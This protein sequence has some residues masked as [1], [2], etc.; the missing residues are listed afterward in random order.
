[1]ISYENAIKFLSKQAPL[2]SKEI[3]ANQACGFIA[4]QDV[5]SDVHVPPFANSAMDGF[6]VRSLDLGNASNDNPVTLNVMGSTVAGDIP[7]GGK[8]G[9]WEI[10]TGAAVPDGYD[11]V[12]RIED[13]AIN[14]KNEGGLA[15]EIILTKPAPI[16]DNIRDAGED[17]VPGTPIINRGEMI[18]P[19]HIMS[20][21]AVGQKNVMV[22]PKPNVVVFSTGK[23]I[24]DDA[25]ASLLPGQIYNSNGP[26]LM[27]ALGEL[28]VSAN[29]GGLI[30]D[31]PEIFK[32][33]IK[34]A[35]TNNDIIISTGAVSAGRHDFIPEALR[36]LGAE[37]IFHKVAIRPGKP[38]L[39]ARFPDGT[40]YFGLPGNPVSA[41]V[42][43]RF[44]VIPLLN[45]LQG[46]PVETPINTRLLMPSP[47]KGNL[48]FFRKAY[49]SVATGGK[50]QLD[51]LKGQE[52]FKIHPL[53]KANCWV[54]F[55]EEQ[56]GNE[57][58]EPI[59]IYPLTPG[60][61]NLNNVS[62]MS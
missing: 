5:T 6:A 44:F 50:L 45:L 23:E 41:A 2:P 19:F 57:V 10:M 33:E 42:G 8:N 20:L 61:W 40:H 17:F 37:I 48:R 7:S 1:M 39:Y 59:D 14:S 46:A 13:V 38:I 51:I 25:D 3:P 27:A 35:L 16:K 58:G 55:K 31:T 12:V 52:S 28:P 29:Y 9:A 30:P 34:Q 56:S 24:I 53:V 21:A 18:T 49:V 22:A 54:V 32:K 11:S 43:L 62:W 15:R 4:A 60:K 47:K 36:E 26:Y